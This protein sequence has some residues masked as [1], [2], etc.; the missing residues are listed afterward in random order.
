MYRT[1]FIFDV[2]DLVQPLN[3]AIDR[4]LGRKPSLQ[5]V[6][7][8]ALYSSWFYHHLY[9]DLHLALLP[10]IEQTVLPLVD[11]EF[12]DFDPFLS[13]RLYTHVS[14]AL[15]PDANPYYECWCRLTVGYHDLM[16]TY[17]MGPV[18]YSAKPA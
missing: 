1:I 6:P 17:D 9:E 15:Y 2:G 10:G 18:D 7:R 11:S 3:E 8:A 13:R 5:S 14:M 12:L 16:L 4:L